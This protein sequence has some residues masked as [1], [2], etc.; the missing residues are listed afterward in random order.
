MD[1]NE[2][3]AAAAVKKGDK[4]MDDG[5]LLLLLLLLLPRLSFGPNITP[6]PQIVHV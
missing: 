2:M 1:E 6:F 4:R 3:T 5:S